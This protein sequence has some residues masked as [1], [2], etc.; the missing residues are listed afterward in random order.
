MEIVWA[1]IVVLAIGQVAMWGFI[2]RHNESIVKLATGVVSLTT[3]MQAITTNLGVVTDGFA[4]SIGDTLGLI[5]E[6]LEQHLKE[7]KRQRGEQV[8]DD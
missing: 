5:S 7:A 1:A 6:H 3:I 2:I 8:D 4:K